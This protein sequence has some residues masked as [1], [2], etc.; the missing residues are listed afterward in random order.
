MLL[1][2]YGMKADPIKAKKLFIMAAEQGHADAQ[3]HLGQMHYQGLGVERNFKEALRYFQAASQAGNL[4][5]VFNLAQMYFL[6]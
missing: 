2:G 3:L 5:A 6:K 1:Y 4:L